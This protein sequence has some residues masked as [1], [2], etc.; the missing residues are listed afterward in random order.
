MRWRTGSVDD[1]VASLARIGPEAYDRDALGVA[2][3]RAIE[4]G[5]AVG[6]N[7]TVSCHDPVAMPVEGTGQPDDRLVEVD[8]SSRTVKVIRGSTV[9][10]SA[11]IGAT[12]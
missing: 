9:W 3:K 2:N 11:R 8:V 10:P 12:R 6:E 7:A 4:L 5:V 1:V